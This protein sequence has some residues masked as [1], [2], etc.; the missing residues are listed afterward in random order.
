M[1]QEQSY[2]AQNNPDGG[3]PNRTAVGLGLG[4]PHFTD[5]YSQ[6]TQLYTNQFQNIQQQMDGLQIAYENAVS[7][8]IQNNDMTKV[9]SLQ[10]T[11]E[12]N[13]STLVSA[14]TQTYT[15]LVDLYKSAGGYQ[16]T[17][18]SAQREAITSAY[19]G[20]ASEPLA[21]SVS[22]AID[23]AGMSMVNKLLLREGVAN[24]TVDLAPTL[25]Y[26]QKFKDDGGILARLGIVTQKF[27][28][29]NTSKM[30]SLASE[31]NDISAGQFTKNV[32]T[33]TTSTEAETILNG[34]IDARKAGG[35]GGV[36][37]TLKIENFFG[38]TE[39]L[40]KLK[41]LENDLSALKKYKDINI[42][43]LGEVYGAAEVAAITKD[44]K[45]FNA[46]NK[47]N[48]ITYTQT[49]DTYYN[50]IGSHEFDQMYI[51]WAAGDGKN[52]KDKSPTGYVAWLAR[53]ATE[54]QKQQDALNGGGDDGGAGDPQAS[55]LDDI[56]K[57][58]RD[59]LN[60]QQKLTLGWD[61]SKKAIK[62]FFKSGKTGFVGLMEN[63]T[64]Q[65]VQDTLMQQ[66]LGLTKEDYEAHK[67]ELID[68][69]GKLTEFGNKFK[70]LIN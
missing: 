8:A 67:S 2:R 22:T 14:N 13:M 63:L 30:A 34:L 51:S 52:E 23:N 47:N 1:L 61:A 42:N 5:T 55:F 35:V 62:D 28:G 39:N 53:Q 4:N 68:Q 49:F 38:K 19:E 69:Y 37:A 45:Y 65:R 41:E 64:G 60:W 31:M 9:K 46:L 12:T 7:E 40:S 10:K 56:V 44:A 25:Q 70:G 15:D 26:L 21:R 48:K 33:A 58:I 17:M 57:G 36:G 18:E 32:A 54:L 3:A 20:T 66:L 59:T 11:Y 16:M 29:V 50:M 6:L 27:G 24:Q 43:I